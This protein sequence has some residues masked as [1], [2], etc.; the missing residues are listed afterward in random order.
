MTKTKIKNK[1]KF[2]KY[3]F[4]AIIPLLILALLGLNINNI[5]T[6]LDFNSI[7]TNEGKPG[8]VVKLES[9]K[10]EFMLML[11]VQDI[12]PKKKMEVIF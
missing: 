7:I 3:L 5:G 11:G 1:F 4:F 6:L 8:E 9:K 10:G 12:I 2:Q